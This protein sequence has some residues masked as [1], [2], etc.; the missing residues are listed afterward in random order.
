M[1][2]GKLPKLSAVKSWMRQLASVHGIPEQVK[3]TWDHSTVIW[4][5]ADQIAIYAIQN[6]Y[7]VDRRFLKI[8][9]YIHDIGKM[10][11]GGW[12][13]RHLRPGIFHIYEGYYFLKNKGFDELANVC[14]C[15]LCGVGSTKSLNKKFGFM[16]KDFF[17]KKI[18]E[19][20]VAYV[21]SRTDPKKGV[22]PFIWPI[23]YPLKHFK[24]YPGVVP[25]L[26]IQHEYIK[27][28]T[29]NYLT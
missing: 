4:H 10:V 25:R 8:A 6:G 5:F 7:S 27:R 26:K 23:S 13:S 1:S 24:K 11:T 29:N 15:H 9:C 19:K 22:G 12:A 14:V 2:Y 18:E 16:P 20:I 3:D 28:I 21:D 17:P